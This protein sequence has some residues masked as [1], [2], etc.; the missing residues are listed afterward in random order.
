VLI[1]LCPFP[2]NIPNTLLYIF[3]SF[4]SVAFFVFYCIAAYEEGTGRSYCWNLKAKEKHAFALSLSK[5]RS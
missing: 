2:S 5:G 3:P 4:F 1:S